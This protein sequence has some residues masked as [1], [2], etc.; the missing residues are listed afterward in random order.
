MSVRTT[1]RDTDGGRER[2]GNEESQARGK[3]NGARGERREKERGKKWRE[4]S[5]RE[6]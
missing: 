4:A 5:V 1:A 2:G 3:D 6:G